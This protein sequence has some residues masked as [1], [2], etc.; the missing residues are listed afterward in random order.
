MYH[1]QALLIMGWWNDTKRAIPMDFSI[2]N[3]DFCSIHIWPLLKLRKKYTTALTVPITE[4]QNGQGWKVP[5]GSW[6][7]NPQPHAGPPTSP[8]NARPGCPGPHPIWPWILPGMGHPQPLWAACSS[9]S[10]LSLSRTQELPPDIQP[11]SPLPQLKI[12]SPCPAPLWEG[13][14]M[15]PFQLKRFY[16]YFMMNKD[17]GIN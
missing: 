10:P 15:G 13:M 7:S 8:F 11:K 12:I 14:I 9:T 17:H 2:S 4:S 1:D 3:I 5:Q 6:I 16:D